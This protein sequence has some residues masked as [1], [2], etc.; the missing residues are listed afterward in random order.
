MQNG[1]ENI[2][3]KEF[4]KLPIADFLESD[5]I[6]IKTA[7]KL[8]NLIRIGQKNIRSAGDEV[9]IELRKFYSRK[10]G[11]NYKVSHGHFVDKQLKV[12]PQFDLLISDASHIQN[13]FKLSDSSEVFPYE[14]IY[15]VGEVK[16]SFYKSDLINTFSNNILNL[17]KQ[18]SREK[19]SPNTLAINNY[20]LTVNDTLS[21]NDYLN[22]LFSFMFFIHSKK[23]NLLKA[24]SDSV[25]DNVALPN[26]ILFL[27]RGILVNIDSDAYNKSIIKVNLYPEFTKNG[28]WVLLTDSNPSKLLS[29]HYLLILSHLEN[30]MLF[31]PKVSEYNANLHV[32][33]I[34][35]YKEL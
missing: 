2:E 16:N 7:S 29:Y 35:Q 3:I 23:N 4:S 20:A 11:N 12:S 15:C 27:D 26:F 5:V 13:L 9:E 18:L 19:M 1:K 32:F 22:P 25:K 28:K 8:S 34:N 33:D 10:L 14:S 6:A 30:T 21:S 24:L 31:Q 17:K